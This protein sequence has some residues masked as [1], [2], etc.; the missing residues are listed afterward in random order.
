MHIT[1][2]YPASLSQKIELLFWGWQRCPGMGGNNRPGISGNNHS[3]MGG[4]NRPESAM[5]RQMSFAARWGSA[6]G[7]LF[8]AAKFLE[9]H[10][11]TASKLG[12][13]P[14]ELLSDRIATLAQPLRASAGKRVNH[15][16]HNYVRC[17]K[18]SR[19]YDRFRFPDVTQGRQNT[20]KRL[21]VSRG[22][23]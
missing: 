20:G 17:M 7:T 12:W 13:I 23:A 3:G 5:V 10:P 15:V 16:C 22:M 8:D 19:N 6:C 18:Y 14:W 2:E 1:S 21:A 9:Q 4:N 11:P